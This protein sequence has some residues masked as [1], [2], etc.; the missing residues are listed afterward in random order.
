MVRVS[1]CFFFQWYRK[2]KPPQLSNEFGFPI[3]TFLHASEAYLVPSLVNGSSVLWIDDILLGLMNPPPDS[4]GPQLLLFYRLIIGKLMHPFQGMYALTRAHRH[5]RESYRGSEFA[6]AILASHNLSI[7]MTVSGL[8]LHLAN[9][10]HK[11]ETS[12][13]STRHKFQRVNWRSP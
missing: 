12:D 5:S 8:F 13:R 10:I 1:A 3:A 11:L 2:L 4:K 6:P 7:I 9:P